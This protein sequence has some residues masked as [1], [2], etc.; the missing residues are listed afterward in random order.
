VAGAIILAYLQALILMALRLFR[1]ASVG[2]AVS[3]VPDTAAAGGALPSTM[4]ATPTSGAWA[5]TTR[6]STRTTTV[7]RTCSVF[8][9]SRALRHEL[10]KRVQGAAASVSKRRKRVLGE[11]FFIGVCDDCVEKCV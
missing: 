10:A 1:A 6:V 11:D 4:P 5:T 3:A 7:R 2:M 9:A 8:A